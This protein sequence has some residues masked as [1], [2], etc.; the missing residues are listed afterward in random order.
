[1]IWGCFPYCGVGP[2]YHKPGTVDQFE[3][4]EILEDAILTCAEEKNGSE[5]GVS[6][7]QQPQTPVSRSILVPDKP[8]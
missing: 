7:R 3:N 4:I 5:M 8:D 6:T 1:M 2:F